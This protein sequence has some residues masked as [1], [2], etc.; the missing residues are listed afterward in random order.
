MDSFFIDRADVAACGIEAG[1]VPGATFEM[2]DAATAVAT[3]SLSVADIL[4]S[5]RRR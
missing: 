5:L 1:D 4:P 2:Y 3:A